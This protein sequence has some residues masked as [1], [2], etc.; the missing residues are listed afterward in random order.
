MAIWRTALFETPTGW[1]SYV[2][3]EIPDGRAYILDADKIGISDFPA[4]GSTVEV[5]DWGYRP[6]RSMTFDPPSHYAIS[7]LR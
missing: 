5:E 3:R 1:R 7:V 6:A 2:V 4:L